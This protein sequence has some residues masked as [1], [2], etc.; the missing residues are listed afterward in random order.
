MKTTRMTNKLDNNSPHVRTRLSHM[1]YRGEM[2][3]SHHI[4]SFIISIAVFTF[5]FRGAFSTASMG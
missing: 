2:G 3:R 4:L 5:G 1:I